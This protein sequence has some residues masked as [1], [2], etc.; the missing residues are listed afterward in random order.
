MADRIGTWDGGYVRKDAR[1][2]D[3][4][5]IRQ[6]VNGQRYEVS[7]RAFSV[8]AALEQLKRFQSDPDAY[9]PRGDERPDPI[10]L[11]KA[12]SE[13]FLTYSREEKKNTVHWV[14]E[15]RTLLADWAEDLHGVDLRRASLRDHILPVLKPGRPSRQ[16]RIALLKSL[17]AWLRTV[18][19]DLTLNEDPTAGGALKVPQTADPAVRRREANKA[20]PRE[21]VE[22]AREHLAGGWRDALD[23]QAATGWHVTEVQRFA[24][25]GEIEP[26]APSQQEM[27]VAGI[28]IVKH[29]SG[30]QHRTGVTATTLEAAQRLR[31]RGGFAIGWYQ[32]AVK[33]ACLAAGL[34]KAFGPGQMRHSVATWA[35][36]S[37]VDLPTVSTFLVHRSASTTQRFYATHA[38]P[39]NPLIIVPP[40]PPPKKQRAR[41]KARRSA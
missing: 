35:V 2:R 23:L 4:Y 34:K 27:G 17:Y 41:R 38:T 13:E 15:Q 9:D 29:K 7:T 28:L 19:R 20:V 30:A 14:S 10:Y 39:K 1:G 33:S 31:E 12:L 24:V 3:V 18:K 5:V 6:Q 25:G 22:L 37:G 40:P 36:D 11:D 32:K 8:K 21:H 26:P 16:H